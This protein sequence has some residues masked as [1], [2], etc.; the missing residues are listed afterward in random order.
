MISAAGTRREPNTSIA[1]S[2]LGGVGGG[3]DGAAADG[4]GAGGAAVGAAG[5]G[6][7]G[8]VIGAGAAGGGA[9]G[10]RAQA[11]AASRTGSAYLI[12]SRYYIRRN[13]TTPIVSNDARIRT[14][15]EDLRSPGN[16]CRE[17]AP[18]HAGGGA[19]GRGRGAI[20]RGAQR[21]EQALADQVGVARPAAG[22]VAAVLDD[23]CVAV[24]VAGAAPG[25][26]A[27]SELEV[28]GPGERRADLVVCRKSVVGSCGAPVVCRKS[29][30]GK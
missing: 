21:G 26:L 1:A 10:E 8:V 5:A 15:P 16:A 2:A 27:R 13:K 3:A 29:A 7:G 6:A 25:Q 30:G 22:D 4:A 17:R 24:V 9:T 11:A 23:E 20:G 18:A 12:R 19:I 28:L 14:L